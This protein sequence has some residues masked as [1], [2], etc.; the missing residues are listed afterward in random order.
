MERAGGER[1]GSGGLQNLIDS[2]FAADASMAPSKFGSFQ[3][4]YRALTGHSNPFVWQSEL[5]GMFLNGEIPEALNLPTGLGKTSVISLWLL[6]LGH[7]AL[8]SPSGITLPRRI[9]W[10]S[11]AC[12]SPKIHSDSNRCL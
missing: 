12:T 11:C 3:D 9:V 8:R 5:F 4:D 2:W 6:A 10:G 1:A 7:Q